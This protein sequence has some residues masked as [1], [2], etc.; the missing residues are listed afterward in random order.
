[1]PSPGAASEIAGLSAFALFVFLT[2]FA[3]VALW[4]RWIVL[5]FFYDMERQGRTIAETQ[6]VRNAEALEATSK[7]LVAA[8][9]EIA[10]LRRDVRLLRDELRPVVSRR[11]DG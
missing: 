6:A 11:P 9:K 7:A 4:R 2:G 3:S 1:V 5:G 8:M 10:G